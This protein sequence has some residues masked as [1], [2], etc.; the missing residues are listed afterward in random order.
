MKPTTV[1]TAPIAATAM[2][3]HIPNPVGQL[4]SVG[5]HAL[6][7][8]ARPSA[9]C[10]NWPTTPISTTAK[11]IRDKPALNTLRPALPA[12]RLT[13][14]HRIPTHHTCC[15][16]PA[17]E[18]PHGHSP[19]SARDRLTDEVDGRRPCGGTL[20][21]VARHGLV[22]D[23]DIVLTASWTPAGGIVVTSSD[24]PDPWHHAL[25]R[26][27]HDLPVR[28]LHGTITHIDF[29]AMHNR[30]TDVVWLSSTVTPLNGVSTPM[31]HDGVGAPVYG[32]EHTI[33]ASCAYLVQDQIAR[34]GVVWPHGRAGGFL[35]ATIH[36]G[37]AL[38]I[39]PDG[40]QTTIGSLTRQ[41]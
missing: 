28:H 6:S 13:M 24:L 8:Q 12:G 5:V 21:A 15:S 29:Q 16:P 38:W 9:G 4:P 25:E 18:L 36:D 37:I 20:N 2:T 33:V 26:L 27:G 35:S 39:G 32:D 14:S 23:F 1:N 22:D 31:A 19:S 3:D 34:A 10:W 41:T 17:A 7:L 40:E 11:T 30:D